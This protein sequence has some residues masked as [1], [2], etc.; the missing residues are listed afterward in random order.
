MARNRRQFTRI[1]FQAEAS[2]LL[3]S[4]EYKVGVVDL[5]LK[6]A[7]IQP[8]DPLYVTVGNNGVLKIRLD[9]ASASI[10]MEVTVVHHQGP[11][12]GLACREIDI[13]SVTHLRQL[14]ALNLGDEALLER[15]IGLL[16][17]A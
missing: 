10:R 15:E 8:Q 2:L 4:S 6:G 12:Y 16:V 5:S 11:C 13:D 17:G 7:L 9:K 14:V 3:A 1:P